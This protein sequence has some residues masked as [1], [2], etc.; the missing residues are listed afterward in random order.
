MCEIDFGMFGGRN[1]L[2]SFVVGD[3]LLGV[4]KVLLSER[5]DREIGPFLGWFCADGTPSLQ[6]RQPFAR[7]SWPWVFRVWGPKSVRVSKEFPESLNNFLRLRTQKTLSET[8]ARG[9]RDCIPSFCLNLS[10][11]LSN[12]IGGPK[13]RSQP[14][15]LGCISWHDLGCTVRVKIITG[16]LVTL[17]NLF[18]K[19]TVTVT[20]LKFGWITIA[21]TVL[22]LAVAPSF[23]IDS[24]LPSRKSFELI[25]SKFPLP[26]PSGN[27]F[28][29]E[30]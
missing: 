13:C 8:P 14:Q 3:Q 11:T 24:Q 21:V 30:R 23:S 27:V 18:P 6:C 15:L 19:I 20:V 7:F 9:G 5:C 12:Q 10:K 16:S 25:S 4:V 17:E 26:L 2:I 1:H 29:L 22:A 28:E